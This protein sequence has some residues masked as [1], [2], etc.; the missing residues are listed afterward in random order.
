MYKEIVKFISYGNIPDDSIL[1]K[2]GDIFKSFEEGTA[3]DAQLT[4]E[5]Y[6][7]IHRLLAIATDYGF[8][9]NLWQNYLTFYL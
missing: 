1:Y 7:Q 8:D 9:G 4:R 6:E 2:L 5:I 3:S